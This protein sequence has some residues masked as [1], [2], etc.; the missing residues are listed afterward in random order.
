M[1]LFWVHSVGMHL[2]EVEDE[3]KLADIPKVAVQ[4]L[5]IVVYELQGDKLVVAGVNAHD[6]VQAGIPLV[7][8][9]EVDKGFQDV[10]A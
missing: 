2:V 7:H 6:K 10:R 4:N 5:H 9:L 1:P 3:V 8:H